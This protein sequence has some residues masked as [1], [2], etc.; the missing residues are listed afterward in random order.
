MGRVKVVED[1]LPSPF[2]RFSMRSIQGIRN[3]EKAGK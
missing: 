2:S 1:F 3:F